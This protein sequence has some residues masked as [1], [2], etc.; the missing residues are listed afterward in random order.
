MKLKYISIAAITTTGIAASGLAWLIIYIS[1]F[2]EGIGFDGPAGG[3]LG[4]TLVGGWLVS[5]IIGLTIFKRHRHGNMI[6]A[7]AIALFAGILV[8]LAI[9]YFIGSYALDHYSDVGHLY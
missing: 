1:N 9:G 3:I 2:Q 6:I 8:S 4:L 7:I 5:S